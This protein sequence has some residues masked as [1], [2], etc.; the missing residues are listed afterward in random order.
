MGHDM[1]RHLIIIAKDGYT[2]DQVLGFTNALAA[3]YYQSL[4]YT[5]DDGG[6]VGKK[7]GVDNP[8]AV[9]TTTWANKQTAPDG[10]GYFTS[11]SND[12]RFVDWKQYWIKAGLPDA[13]IEIERP[14]D[15]VVEDI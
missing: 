12:P 14:D 6:I 11:L 5:K 15:W 8:N 10:T 7:N 4:G 13:Y 3:G 2:I 1:D 9:R